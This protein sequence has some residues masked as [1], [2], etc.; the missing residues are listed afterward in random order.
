MSISQFK[1]QAGVIEKLA[2][3]GATVI[4]ALSTE[5]TQNHAPHLAVSSS[6]PHSITVSFYG[7]RLVFRIEIDWTASGTNAKIVAYSLSYDAEPTETSLVA[8]PFDDLGNVNRMHTANEFGAPLL[9]EVFTMLHQTGII[10][11][12]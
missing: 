11:R 12:P 5:I 7:F 3:K 10:L 9:A 8:Y 6:T 2:N 4:A 1:H